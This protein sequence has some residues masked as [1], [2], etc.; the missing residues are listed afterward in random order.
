MAVKFEPQRSVAQVNL[1]PRRGSGAGHGHR[2]QTGARSRIG[3]VQTPGT[4]SELIPAPKLTATGA[5]GGGEPGGWKNRAVMQ[6]RRIPGPVRAAV[7]RPGLASVREER[8]R[9]GD[10][11]ARL[12]GGYE[13]AIS[14]QIVDVVTAGA[15]QLIIS[16]DH[17]RTF[18]RVRCGGGCRC[19]TPGEALAVSL[20]HQ[21]APT[22]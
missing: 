16:T 13:V 5:D 10:V 2:A 8:A 6:R 11:G 7:H 22:A 4:L 18:P 14:A 20:I 12:G 17:R 1:R 19:F 9:I 3:R 21:R 15:G